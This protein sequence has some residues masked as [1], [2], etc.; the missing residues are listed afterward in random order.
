MGPF[1]NKDHLLLINTTFYHYFI[2]SALSITFHRVF[3]MAS[4]NPYS[5][6]VVT[7]KV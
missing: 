3:H 7:A 1:I 6:T 4:I 5:K 2:S